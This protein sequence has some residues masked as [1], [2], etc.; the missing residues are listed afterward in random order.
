MAWSP[1]GFSSSTLMVSPGLCPL[2]LEFKVALASSVEHRTNPTWVQLWE[3][4]GWERVG[5]RWL[6][7]PGSEG[8]KEKEQPHCVYL[9][10]A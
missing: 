7:G 10:L 2:T 8:G 6:G 5:D 9:A 1:G 4:P 3:T